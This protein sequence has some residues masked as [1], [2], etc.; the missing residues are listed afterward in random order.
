M[1]ESICRV[2]NALFCYEECT[3]RDLDYIDGLIGLAKSI[4][5]NLPFGS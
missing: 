2:R 5:R 4:V 1:V 3:T